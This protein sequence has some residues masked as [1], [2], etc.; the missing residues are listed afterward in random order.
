MMNRL[1]LL[2]LITFFGSAVNQAHAATEKIPYE[3]LNALNNAIK[4]ASNYRLRQYQKIDSIKRSYKTT[5][6]SLEEWEKKYRVAGAYRLVNADSAIYYAEAAYILA[7][8]LHADNKLPADQV[9]RT[10]FVLV[11]ALGTGGIFTVAKSNFETIGKRKIPD[12]L[13]VEYWRSGYLLY[14]YMAAALGNN[15]QYAT[16]AR[17]AAQNYSDSL[18]SRLPHND[19]LFRQL[20]IEKQIGDGQYEEAKDS[21]EALLTTLAEDDYQYGK[22]LMQ[23]ARIYKLQGN[24]YKYASNLARAASSDIKS[25][26][27]EGMAL[28]ALSNWLFEREEI[29]DAYH[30][31]NFALEDAALST[32]R[33]RTT[34]I[35]QLVPSIDE[36]YRKKISDSRNQL[37]A[38]FIVVA[39]LLSLTVTLV[40]ILIR[41]NK[42]VHKDQEKLAKISQIQESYLGNF[43]ALCSSYANGL[44]SLTKLVGRK[45]SSGQADELLKM[46]KSGR[47]Q[48][49][50]DDEDFYKLFDNAFLDMYPNFV[51]NVNALLRPEERIEVRPGQ[52]LTPELRIYAF[53]KLGV[54]ESVK[55]AQ[56]L[57]YSASTVYAYRNRM[58]NRA[59]DRE[60]FDSQVAGIGR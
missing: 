24:E 34:A 54:D 60:N 4:H 44:D 56:I 40:V 33:M 30:Y 18:L 8:R 37:L 39:L 7:E 21:A 25:S 35:A 32:A 58:R 48:G 38:W 3:D 9:L 49:G 10:I 26:V 15:T 12:H 55:I 45:L 6:Y 57:R 43:V 27:T 16:E 22:T 50:Q 42:R 19:V 28:P 47:L 23:L 53:V 17:N 31:I 14:S 52:G 5:P 51:A 36:A 41:Q 46:V 29:D 59:I 11:D 1:L 2:I 13:L 20:T